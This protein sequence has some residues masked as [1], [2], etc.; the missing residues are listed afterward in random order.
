MRRQCLSV[1]LQLISQ[2][3][4]GIRVRLLREAGDRLEEGFRSVFPLWPIRALYQRFCPTN[5][6]GSAPSPYGGEG[7]RG[8]KGPFLLALNSNQSW[9]VLE[10]GFL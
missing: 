1:S 8:P 4:S 9:Q 7:S 5:Q 10:R 6:R 3:A 2:W